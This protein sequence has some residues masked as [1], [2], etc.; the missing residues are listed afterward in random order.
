MPPIIGYFRVKNQTIVAII[1]INCQETRKSA[2]QTREISLE[3]TRMK[4]LISQVKELSLKAKRSS[5]H[6][7]FL[8]GTMLDPNCQ[9]LA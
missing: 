3:L 4:Q 9:A 1:K 8:D 7:S 2:T 5:C 6:R